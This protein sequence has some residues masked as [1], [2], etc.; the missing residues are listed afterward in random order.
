MKEIRRIRV[1]V[2]ISDP[3][4][5]VEYEELPDGWDEMTQAD[6]DAYLIELA[7]LYLSNQA[8]SGACVVDEND[9]EVTP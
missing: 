5:T 8:G 3:N 1:T 2:E 7:M 6:R 9:D 4:T